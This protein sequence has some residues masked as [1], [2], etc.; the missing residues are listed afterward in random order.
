MTSSWPEPV[1]RVAAFLRRAG[2][3]A[4]LEELETSARTDRALA[5]AAGC[6]LEQIG[7]ASV[8]LCGGRP[9]VVLVPGGR[10]PDEAKVARAAGSE[11]ARPARE[12]E[13]EGLTGFPAGS[14]APFPLPRTVAHVFVDRTLLAHDL[15]WVGAGSPHHLA[16]VR[17]PELLRLARGEPMDA[18]Q[19]R[20]YDEGP[21]D[22]RQGEPT[23]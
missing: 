7:S 16:A 1:E 14:L 12:D 17:P 22:A 21:G 10:R 11:T 20:T 8:F 19:E 5:E 15:V 23:G 4:R 18:V 13:V 2:A 6:T 9:V 3:E